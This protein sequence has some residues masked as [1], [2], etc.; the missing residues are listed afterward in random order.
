MGSEKMT[1]ELKPCPFCNSKALVVGKDD[2]GLYVQCLD[3]DA[4][5]YHF[6]DKYDEQKLVDIWN[7]R[8]KE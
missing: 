6:M 5:L 4:Q 1:E 7:R 8:V 3:C 2:N